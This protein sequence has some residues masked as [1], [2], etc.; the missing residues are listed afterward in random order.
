MADRIVSLLPGATEWICLLGLG[1]RL[2][3]VSHE[4]D[5]PSK[6]KALPRV[7][8]TRV[9]TEGSSRQIDEQ[10]RRHVRSR[11]P[12][13]RLDSDLLVQ[14]NPDLIVTQS[15]CNVCAVHQEDVLRCV[16]KIGR[17]CRLLTLQA[18]TLEQVMAEGREILS[19]A[20]ATESG[21]AALEALERRADEI[22]RRALASARPRP[23][24]TLLE[25]LDPLFCSGHWTPTLIDWAG[26]IDPIGS[27]GQPSRVI[28]PETLVEAD[29]DL[30]LVACC[31]LTADRASNELTLLRQLP[32]WSELNCSDAVHVFDGSAFFNRPGP[33]L[34]DALESVADL[35][36]QWHQ[37][38]AVR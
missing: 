11:E 35:V 27:P 18:Q 29:P 37:P 16:D 5:F 21:V 38:L 20:G 26:G 25:W 32:G 33:R 30:L 4:C 31:G 10:V 22:R 24:V 17:D 8:A 12:L 34:V 14:L 19:A 3:G 6:V 15:L 28:E 36:D 23:R 9:L 2:V 1:E 7:T 13:Y